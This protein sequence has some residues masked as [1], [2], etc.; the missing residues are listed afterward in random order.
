MNDH[1]DIGAKFLELYGKL[2]PYKTRTPRLSSLEGYPL[3]GSQERFDQF[4]SALVN[5]WIPSQPDKE[6]LMAM[7]IILGFSP[8]AFVG[9]LTQGPDFLIRYANNQKSDAGSRPLE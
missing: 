8:T 3:E 2:L 9:V 7:F 6:A 5:E 4:Y 1:D